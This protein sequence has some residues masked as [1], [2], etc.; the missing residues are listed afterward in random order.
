V[1]SRPAIATF[2]CQGFECAPSWRW[3][4]N[5]K[6]DGLRHPPAAGDEYIDARRE[7]GDARVAMMAIA[8]RLR[9]P[10]PL[11]LPFA[12]SWNDTLAGQ[13]ANVFIGEAC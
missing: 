11:H 6:N 1:L 9:L 7:A 2:F 4:E 13:P 10:A 3:A 12:A 5:A 8:L